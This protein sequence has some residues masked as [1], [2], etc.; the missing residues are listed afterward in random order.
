M[1]IGCYGNSHQIIQRVRLVFSGTV[2][3]DLLSLTLQVLRAVVFQGCVSAQ[4]LEA[5]QKGLFLLLSMGCQHLL[6]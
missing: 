1:I 4:I 2:T 6:S 3:V 5:M